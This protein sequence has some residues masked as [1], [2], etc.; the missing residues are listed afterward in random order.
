MCDF[1]GGFRVPEMVKRRPVVVISPKIRNRPGL[2]TV[3]PLSTTAP[4]PRMAY[5]CQIEIEPP[6]PER[7]VSSGLWVKGDMICT[8]SLERLDFIRTGKR[9]DGSRK[10]YFHRLDRQT[11]SEIRGRVLV[12]L[13]LSHLTKH[14]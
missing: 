10:Y 14:L 8:V 11:M 3:V 5:H 1:G 9:E 13:G 12:G 4:A 7:F 2:C 6:L